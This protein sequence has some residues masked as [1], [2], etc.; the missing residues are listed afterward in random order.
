MTRL[1]GERVPYVVEAFPEYNMRH[2]SVESALYARTITDGLLNI[3]FTKV[4]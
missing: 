2:L 3:E 1:L 4:Q